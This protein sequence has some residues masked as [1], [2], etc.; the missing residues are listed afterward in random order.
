MDAAAP[1][2]CPP[3]PGAHFECF[4]SAAIHCAFPAIRRAGHPCSSRRRSALRHRGTDWGRARSN[5]RRRPAASIQRRPR[6]RS[7]ELRA[8]AVCRD[9]QEFVL[10]RIQR[11]RVLSLLCRRILVAEQPVGRLV[12]LDGWK[13]ADFLIGKIVVVVVVVAH[14]HFP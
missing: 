14:G 1:A 2:S 8:E 4:V 9:G 7:T 11:R 5:T 10:N 12:L 3:D 6:L 13:T